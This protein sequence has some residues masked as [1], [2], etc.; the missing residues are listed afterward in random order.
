MQRNLLLKISAIVHEVGGFISSRMHHKHSYYLVKNSEIFGLEQS[1]LEVIAQVARYHRQSPP[2]QSHKEYRNLS[3]NEQV[4]VS[5]P[6]IHCKH[7]IPY[8]NRELSW[9]QFNQ[10]V[11]AESMREDL[12]LLER[13][14]FLAIS[15]S[16]LD[17]FFQVRIGGLTH[18]LHQGVTGTDPSG[19]TIS[20]QLHQ[21][22]EQ[23]TSM[24]QD[25][26]KHWRETLMPKLASENIDI[27]K[28]E[29]LTNDQQNKAQ[30]KVE[31]EFIPVLIHHP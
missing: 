30:R 26:Y 20:A 29:E 16:N 2:K 1:A 23:A 18:D 17:E 9:L 28:Y 15:G 13:V 22:R 8:T 10:R 31:A 3:R 6:P 11:L 14:K 19:M 24:M 27:L 4:L 25:Q 7:M 12:P 5:K 21:M